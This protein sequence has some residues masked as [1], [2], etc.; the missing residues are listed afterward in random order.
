MEQEFLSV[1]EVA[2]IFAVNEVTVR[3]AIKKGWIIAF[4]IGAGKRSPYRISKKSIENVHLNMI[5]KQLN[6]K[7]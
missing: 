1:K 5:M 3:R 6:I 4:K 2:V 7:L